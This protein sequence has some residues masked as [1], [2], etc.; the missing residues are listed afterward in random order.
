MYISFW[1]YVHLN[2]LII[3]KLNNLFDEILLLARYENQKENLNKENICLNTT[4]IE[5]L[6]NYSDKIKSK[7]LI[8]NRQTSGNCFVNS[9]QNLINIII[10]NLISNAIKYS[11]TDNK[12]DLLI[13]EENCKTV[14]LIID[15]GDGILQNDL[16]NIYR[17]FFR[18]NPG[19]N[20]DI[21]GNGLGLSIVLKLC[22]LLQIDLQIESQESNGTT[23]K[24][25][26]N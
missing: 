26:F 4:L 13:Q 12:I 3:D 24:L 17:P 20:P 14:L 9:D 23:A 2:F 16:T 15:F 7:N 25:I 1:I 19:K 22:L 10:S 18:S 5:I 11:K 8:I 6:L 21:T